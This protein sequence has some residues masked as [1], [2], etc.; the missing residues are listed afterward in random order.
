MRLPGALTSLALASL[1][2]GEARALSLGELLSFPLAPVTDAADLSDPTAFAPLAKGESYAYEVAR[3]GVYD[4]SGNQPDPNDPAT[5]T[6]LSYQGTVTLLADAC[7]GAGMGDLV[8]VLTSLREGSYAPGGAL[9]PRVLGGYVES[10]LA[11]DDYVFVRDPLDDPAGVI[12]DEEGEHFLALRFP[13]L[14]GEPQSF[15]FQIALRETLEGTLEHFNRGF[16][17]LPQPVPEPGTLTT[18]GAALAAL[19]ALRR[20]R[21]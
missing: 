8:L 10:T 11:D 20:A 19:S 4:P 17:A 18:L 21:R 5:W 13:A 12:A 7:S 1:V 3:I 14:P 16:L 6:V 9:P 15:R 2:A